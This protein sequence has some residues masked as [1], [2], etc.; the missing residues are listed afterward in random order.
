MYLYSTYMALWALLNADR[1][2]VVSGTAN[3][4]LCL[5]KFEIVQ[6]HLVSLEDL[7]DARFDL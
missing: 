3:V 2:A 1:L 7:S 6:S 5:I 4:G